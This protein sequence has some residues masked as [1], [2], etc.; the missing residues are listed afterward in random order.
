MCHSLPTLAL[1]PSASVDAFVALVKPFAQP[2]EQQRVA[3]FGG[4]G[5]DASGS[6]GGM[7]VDFAPDGAIVAV[8]Q[9]G[10]RTF[11][12][13][14]GA[15]QPEA[16]GFNLWVARLS[17][18]LSELE[19]A[20]FLGGNSFEFPNG[21]VVDS[22]G[23]PIITGI[24]A[25]TD[26][27]LVDPIDLKPLLGD[28]GGRDYIFAILS[29]DLSELVHSSKFGDEGWELG[30]EVDLGPDGSIYFVGRKRDGGAEAGVT[31]DVFVVRLL[32]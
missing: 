23:Q 15:Y 19:H 14:D 18:D 32:P 22:H 1:V 3:T 24:S 20:T 4:L 6:A 11:P 29:P 10:S 9:S 8:G 31:T 13:T 5:F 28:G 26:Y 17:A 30:G 25:S 7:H 12:I 2:S 16:R 21:L 27:P